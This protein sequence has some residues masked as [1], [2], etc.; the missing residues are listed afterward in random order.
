M[1]AD[2][3]KLPRDVEQLRQLVIESNAL[4]IEANKKIVVL[5]E[6]L[7]LARSWRYGRSADAVEDQKQA[8][9]F[10]EAEDGAAKA[11]ETETAEQTVTVA[12]HERKKAGRRPLPANLPRE[13]IVHDIPEAEKVCACG[14]RLSRIGEE[15]SE[16]LEVIPARAKVIRHIRPKY[17][18][19][20]C[21]GVE[22]EGGAVKIAPPA[23]QLLPRSIATPG[24]LAYLM[25]SKFADSL[26]FYRQERIFARMGVELSRATMCSWAMEIADR[27]APILDLMRARI[28]AGPYVQIDETRLQVLEDLGATSQMWVY[29]GGDPVSPTVVYAY[30]PS[31]SGD[32]PYVFLD[33]YRGWVQ[34]DGYA[35]YEKLGRR[36]GVM[37]LGCWAHARRKF[38]EV[39]KAA[40]GGSAAHEA[41]EYIR[42]LYAVESQ[43]E[44]RGLDWQQLAMERAERSVPALKEFRL[45]LERLRD[46]T[47]PQG[48]LGKAIAY[49]LGQWDRLERYVEHGMLRPDN[50]L[51]ENAIRPFVVGRKNWLFS[52]TS[53]GAAA[54]AALYSVITTAKANG[55]EPYWYLRFLFDGLVRARS[56]AE[57]TALLP[58]NVEP[59]A[60]I[61]AGR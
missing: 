5:E 10:N 2:V 3:S 6:E 13:E 4:L 27:L 25:V 49:T 12:A 57:L 24:L 7:R 51:A 38:V 37:M 35:G 16:Q 34:T 42:R 23:E 56:E 20:A 8:R 45:W 43:A 61:P 58:Q 60:L 53:R 31:R 36:D 39:T 21:Q 11:A 17:A 18:C 19:R 44:S 50:N 15:V 29:R 41:L 46:Q 47:P 30:H 52:A 48:L 54:S 33:G 26:P 28:R 55:H 40:A 14:A 9:L 22:T 59:K 1:T 32:V